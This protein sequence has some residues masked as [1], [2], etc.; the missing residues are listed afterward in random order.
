MLIT[1]SFHLPPTHPT[2]DIHL[3]LDSLKH[4]TS[5]D[6]P[7]VLLAALHILAHS[8]LITPVREVPSLPVYGVGN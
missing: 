4:R 8:F 7:W 3:S 1:F 5:M 6:L 2:K